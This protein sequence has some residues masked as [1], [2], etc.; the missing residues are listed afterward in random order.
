MNLLCICDFSAEHPLVVESAI[1]VVIVRKPMGASG[2]CSPESRSSTW[3][4]LHVHLASPKKPWL[5][6]VDSMLILQLP[7]GEMR[8]FSSSHCASH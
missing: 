2:L 4:E 3:I 6:V 7:V 1:S 8:T 5:S